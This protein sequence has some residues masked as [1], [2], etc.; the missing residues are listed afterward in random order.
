MRGTII[1]WTG[2][3]GVVAAA[4]QRYD[5]DI[6]QWAGTTAPAVNINVDLTV[7]DGRITG[8][9]PVDE[10]ALAKE[11]LAEMTGK[12]SEL[13]RAVYTHVGK[14]VVIAYAGFTVAALIAGFFV[15]NALPQLGTASGV[16]LTLAEILNGDLHGDVAMQASRGS[17]K[18]IFLVLL[19][20]AT[21]AVPY[22]SR[23]RHAPLA[24]C[25]PL[26]VAGYGVWAIYRQMQLV[27]DA[28]SSEIARHSGNADPFFR[29]AAEE[30]VQQ[31]QAAL[32][33]V[34][35]AIHI[36]IGGWILLAIGAY[37]AYQ[38]IARFLSRA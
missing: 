13:A 24:F 37:L 3:K 9:T 7:T 31:V 11:K 16:S 28:I 1:M 12:G 14:D 32:Q 19:T 33:Q 26:G 6:H 5:F 2:E 35:E 30:S 21:V 22:F 8:V 18:G 25:V 15:M 17:A 20:A 10:A 29:R 36:G 4:G 23:Q 34:D 38:G 27:R